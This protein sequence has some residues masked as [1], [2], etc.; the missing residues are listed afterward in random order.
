MIVRGGNPEKFEKYFKK[1]YEISNELGREFL[2]I[3]AWNEW[4][5]G[6]YLEADERN[7]FGYL[8]AIKNVKEHLM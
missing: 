1:Q 7:K 6:A 4:G 5:E 3:N 2:F 8:E